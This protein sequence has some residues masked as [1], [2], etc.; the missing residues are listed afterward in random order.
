MTKRF[1]KSAGERQKW[2]LREWR[3]YRGLTQE[4]LAEAIEST[5]QT[6]SRMESGYS[7][8]NQPF[9]EACADA[10]DVKAYELLLG[11]PSSNATVEELCSSLRAQPTAKLEKIKS[12]L[13]LLDD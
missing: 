10:L 13:E 6:V 8:Y 3:K 12:F 9:L 7:P 1:G 2:Y 5:K 11:A 4:Q